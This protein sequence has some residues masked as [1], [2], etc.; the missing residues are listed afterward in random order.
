MVPDNFLKL[1]PLA[2]RVYRI[3]VNI[4]IMWI[5]KEYLIIF[6][7]QVFYNTDWSMFRISTKNFILDV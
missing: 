7:F 1:S 2:V 3:D 6:V 4:I 5:T